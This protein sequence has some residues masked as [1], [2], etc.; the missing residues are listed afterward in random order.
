MYGWTKYLLHSIGHCPSGAAAQKE[1][2][3]EE[4]KEKVEEEEEQETRPD[5]R[6]QVASHHSPTF[7]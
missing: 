5:T 2:E 6:H 1:G 4:E 3:E 7:S